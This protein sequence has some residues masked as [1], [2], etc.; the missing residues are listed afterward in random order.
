MTID[1][2][3]ALVSELA[4][5]ELPIF[6]ATAPSYDDEHMDSVQFADGQI[7]F[8]ADVVTLSVIAIPVARFVGKL[9]EAMVVGALTEGAKVSLRDSLKKRMTKDKSPAVDA[10]PAE[11][12]QRARAAAFD[13]AAAL[14]LEPGRAQLLADAIAGCLTVTPP[15][16]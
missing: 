14:G 6:E 8:G 7:G 12:V 13:Q 3:R 2:A 5:D 4:P 1:L 9:V 15:S 11:V 16:A 10:L